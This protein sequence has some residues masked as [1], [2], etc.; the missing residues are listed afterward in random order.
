MRVERIKA[1]DADLLEPQ[2][3]LWGKVNVEA[4]ELIATPLAMVR[5][6]S[7]FLALSE[8]HGAVGRL[9]V[10][11]VHNGRML[12]VRLRWASVKSDR[13]R[14]L[15]GFVDGAAVMF[16]AAT[17]VS[18]ITMGESGKP[19]N[20]WYWKADRAAPYEVLAEGFRSVQRLGDARASD[21]KAAATYSDGRWHVVFRRSLGA[22]NRLVRFGPGRRS[23]IAFAIWSGANAERSGRKSFSGEFASL[24][25]AA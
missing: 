10:Q 25:V 11:A 19:V 8:G 20:A 23:G 13:V 14:D 6:L 12:A 9:D 2:E 3:P 16:P 7:P 17:G 18:A 4:V 21:L 15:D 24:E 22:R 1:A 5:E